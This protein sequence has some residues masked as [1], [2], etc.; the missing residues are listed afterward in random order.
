M[1][2]KLSIPLLGAL[3]NQSHFTCSTCATPHELFGSTAAFERMAD[4]LAMDV[5]GRLPLVPGVSEGGD[6]GRPF[7]VQSDPAGDEVRRVMSEVA[8]R[9]VKAVM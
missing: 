2:R 4:D 5:L 9:V 1:F 8:A 6:Q 7:M 3:I